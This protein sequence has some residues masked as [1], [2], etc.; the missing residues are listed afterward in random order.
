MGSEI[1]WGD[2]IFQ[3]ILISAS[4]LFFAST[5]TNS[6]AKFS[7]IKNH[8]TTLIFSRLFSTMLFQSILYNVHIQLDVQRTSMLNESSQESSANFDS[9]DTPTKGFSNPHMP[10]DLTRATETFTL[11]VRS[12]TLI[13]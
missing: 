12:T 2:S 3:W 10:S 11:R 5:T 9:F 13:Q 7:N 1:N 6:T 8:S 4:I